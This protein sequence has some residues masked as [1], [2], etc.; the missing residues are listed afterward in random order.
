MSFRTMKSLEGKL[1]SQNQIDITL[2]A[3]DGN[4]CLMLMVQFL[5]E[6]IEKFFE[7]FFLRRVWAGFHIYAAAIVLF[8]STPVNTQNMKNVGDDDD[9]MLCRYDARLSIFI[10]TGVFSWV[11]L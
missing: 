1:C 9:I 10:L 7:Y 8:S 5:W 3:D 11:D 2:S 6:M 4:G